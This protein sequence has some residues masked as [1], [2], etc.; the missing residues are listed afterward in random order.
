MSSYNFMRSGSSNLNHNS[1]NL[2][3]SQEDL[4]NLLNLFISNAIITASKYTS[5]CKRNGVTKTDLNYGLKFETIEFFRRNTL[6]EDFNELKQDYENM[7]DEPIIKYKIEYINGYTGVLETVDTL[8]DTEEDVDLYIDNNLANEE[9]YKD[10]T[11]IELTQSDLDMDELITDDENIMEFSKISDENYI[12]L[13]PSDKEF[14]DKLHDIDQ[15]WDTWEPS[16]PI[17]KIMKDLVSKN[18]L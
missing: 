4:T 18:N 2:P 8:F 12:T 6:V 14:V 7:K 17:Q 3:F 9:K 16:I 15:T 13:S 11:F 5:I 10:I 1:N